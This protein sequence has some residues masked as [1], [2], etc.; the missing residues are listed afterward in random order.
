[1]TARDPA[2]AVSFEKLVPE[3]LNSGRFEIRLL[4]QSPADEILKPWV[5]ESMLFA[6]PNDAFTRVLEDDFLQQQF[7]S[8]QP[9]AVLTGISGPDTGM[10]EAVLHYAATHGIRSYA[11]QSFW[12]DMN[13][14]SGAL[15]DIAFV[16]DDE[17]ARITHERY[18]Q[19]VSVPIGSIK[20][21]D[22]HCYD[23]LAARA[24][25][26][27]GLV[28]KDEVILGFY[29]QPIL[30]IAGYFATLEALSRQLKRWSRPFRLLYRPHPK[31]TD[32][33]RQKTLSLFTGAFGERVQLDP[34]DD[35]KDSL[36]VCDLVLSA[37]STC[38]F[39]NLYLNELAPQPFNASVYLWFDPQL[40][41]WWRDYS[42]LHDMPLISEQL[43]LS[44]DTEEEMLTVLEKGLQAE[45]RQALWHRA[46][47]HLPSPQAAIGIVMEK[48]LADFD[49]ERKV[50]HG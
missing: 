2:T 50:I 3:L 29:G 35:I 38:C 26:R 34:F 36:V 37:F 23:P 47:Q 19:V 25:K 12:G 44:V 27:P 5:P 22:Y 8:F 20:H 33:L 6:R 1:M 21:I 18:P 41:Q 15:P 43:L 4:C 39:D 42:Q 7:A 24:E 10:D 16:M 31:E 46:K 40:I 28:E 48:L 32:V 45:T 11:L 49:T 13:Q 9:D 30:E 14:A 17:A